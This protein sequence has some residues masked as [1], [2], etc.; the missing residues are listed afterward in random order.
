MI[1]KRKFLLPRGQTIVELLLAMSLTGIFLPV[2]LTSFTTSREGRVQDNQR[3]RATQLQK[4]AVEA[5]RSVRERGWSEIAT[6]GTYHPSV[7]GTQWVLATGVESTDGFEREIVI[8]DVLRNNDGEIVELGGEVDPSAKR[9]DVNIRWSVPRDSLQSSTLYLS[10]LSNDVYGETTISEF[11][12]GE[13][14]GTVIT[15]TNGGEIILGAGGHGNW[16]E[17]EVLQSIV[18]LPGSGIAQGVTAIEGKA[19]VGT[20]ENS[21]GLSFMSVNI[22]NNDPPAAVLAG[23][24]NGH[25]TNDVFGEMN[26]GYIS[27]D[28]NSREVIIVDIANTPFSEVGYADLPGNGNGES[29][30][31]SGNTGY[32]TTGN[33]LYNFNLTSK[34][35]SRPMIDSSGVT[36]SGSATRVF[37]VGNYAYVAVTGSPELQIIDLSSPTNLQVVGQAD[38]NSLGAVD[39]FANPSGTRAYLATGG[40]ASQ[41]EMFIIDIST[42]TGNRPVVGTYDTQGMSPRAIS[43]TT[44]NR[45]I[46]VGTNGEEYQV[47]DITT[48]ASPIRCGGE[49]VNEG[50]NGVASVLESDNDAY[51]YAVTNNASAEFKLIVGG[52]G[53]SF[54]DDGIFTSQAY[55]AS[56]SAVFNRIIPDVTLPPTTTARFQVA[57]A[58]QVN[59]N[60]TNANYVFVGPDGTGTTFFDQNGGAI[61]FDSDNQGF[62]NPGRCL[63]YKVF[64]T[65]GD[66]TATPTV[67]SVSF[68]FS[69]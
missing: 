52:P 12:E 23:E 64:L 62:E 20:G 7:S 57:V 8:S 9:I 11:E 35:G 33:K 41:R 40:A 69:L 18:D 17:P 34:S 27:T 42:K 24:F 48:E 26:Y 49:Q 25:K 4:E 5:V 36:L 55:T 1:F 29:I 51:S 16:C 68:N 65:T 10:R 59:N 53:G 54:V 14:Q 37:V 38:T 43:V 19:F 32:A 2:L 3:I 31:V 30:F 50:I 13:P 28:T 56:T 22:N 61:P 44:G 63:K 60:C 6:N 15:N 47:V 46:I 21:S 45:G 39:V 58:S 67:N 66:I